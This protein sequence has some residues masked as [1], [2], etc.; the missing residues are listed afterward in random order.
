MPGVGPGSS[1]LRVAYPS[2]ERRERTPRAPRRSR[3][4][5]YRGLA[6]GHPCHQGGRRPGGRFSSHHPR[7]MRESAMDLKIDVRPKKGRIV[8]TYGHRAQALQSEGRTVV[9][10]DGLPEVYLTVT[11]LAHKR[12]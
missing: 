5:S 2:A 11:T 12:T 8:T 6:E 10:A 4:P 7:K 9:Y 3:P 1:G